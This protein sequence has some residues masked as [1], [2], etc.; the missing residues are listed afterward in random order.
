M[1]V[2]GVWLVCFHAVRPHRRVLDPEHDTAIGI[3]S[4]VAAQKSRANS[5]SLASPEMR[6]SAKVLGL[7]SENAQHLDL[8]KG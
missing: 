7:S 1:R 8:V 4:L 2:A 3:E 6:S 5:L